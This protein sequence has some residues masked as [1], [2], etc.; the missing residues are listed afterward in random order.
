MGVGF[1]LKE[2][3]RDRKTTIKQLSKDADIPLNTLYSITKRDSD[4]VDSVI[5]RRIADALGI[6]VSE[7]LDDKKSLQKAINSGIVSPTDIANELA[8]SVEMVL[9]AINSPGTVP[10]EFLDKVVKVGNMLAMEFSGKDYQD[11]QKV[12]NQLLPVICD[13]NP[14]GQ[15]EAVKRVCE[16]AEVP[17]YQRTPAAPETKK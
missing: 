8:T 9:A 3:L 2:I 13:L 4:R 16:L 10:P 12:M 5:L 11:A 15:R 6:H 7:L 1:R 17:K 14:A